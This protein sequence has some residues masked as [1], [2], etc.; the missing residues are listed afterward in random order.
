MT[1][2]KSFG[3]THM[4]PEIVIKSFLIMRMQFTLEIDRLSL[5]EQIVF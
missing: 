5:R 1:L 4:I 2:Q 3:L